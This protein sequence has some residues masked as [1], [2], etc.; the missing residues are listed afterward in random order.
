MSEFKLTNR[1]MVEN[2]LNTYLNDMKLNDIKSNDIYR[3][4]I[5]MS[6]QTFIDKYSHNS[7]YT[8]TIIQKL[9]DEE[10]TPHTLTLLYIDR[11]IQPRYNIFNDFVNL[12]TNE[13]LT[14][15]NNTMYNVFT[16]LNK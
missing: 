16:E 13:E 4:I 7:D 2:K 11:F 14:L 8:N 6:L 1:N 5:D 15:I 10:F 9:L 12:F 3:D